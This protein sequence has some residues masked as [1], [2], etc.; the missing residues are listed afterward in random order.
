[1]WR[2]SRVF[3]K[4]TICLSTALKNEKF[5]YFCLFAGN[6]HTRDSPLSVL[7]VA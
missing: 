2:I 4:S 3:Q 1:M 5:T 7:E 6:E